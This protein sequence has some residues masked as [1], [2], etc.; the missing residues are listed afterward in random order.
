MKTFNEI[1]Y[2]CDD[3]KEL[4]YEICTLDTNISSK[5]RNKNFF[6]QSLKNLHV[7]HSS[8][9]NIIYEF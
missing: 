1:H 9:R 6:P 3:S 5:P 8:T 2:I 7:I 4:I